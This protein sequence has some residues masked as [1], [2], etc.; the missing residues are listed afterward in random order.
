MIV[1]GGSA[2]VRAACAIRSWKL[3]AIGPP[4]ALP[5]RTPFQSTERS[6]QTRPSRQASPG[7]LDGG[8]FGGL[9]LFK[10]SGVNAKGAPGGEIFHSETV[11]DELQL[12]GKTGRLTYV[13]GLFYSRQHR[14]QE[15]PISFGAD[16]GLPAPIADIA[17]DY[18]NR[19]SSKAIFGQIGY[20]L[21]DQLT[22]NVGGRYTW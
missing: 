5:K 11:T 9:W 2:R 7:N 15:I 1:P 18:R 20:Q 12:Q 22:V 3:N 6:R 10:L 14:I 21:T 17:Y 16:L 19:E 8:P 4:F 13:A